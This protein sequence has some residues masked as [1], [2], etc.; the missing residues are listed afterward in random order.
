MVNRPLGGGPL[1]NTQYIYRGADIDFI[2]GTLLN[3]GVIRGQQAK[4]WVAIPEDPDRDYR[5]GTRLSEIEWE[6]FP[7]NDTNFDTLGVT[8]G[9]TDSLL[10]T[11]RFTG[12]HNT[13][14]VFDA[15]MT[16]FEKVEYTHE[17]M[18]EHA[19]ALTQVLKRANGEIHVPGRGL[20][21]TT[22]TSVSADG[23]RRTVILNWGKDNLPATNPNSRFADENEWIANKDSVTVSGAFKGIVS[24]LTDRGASLKLRNM[25][26]TIEPP[27]MPDVGEGEIDLIYNGLMDRLNRFNEPLYMVILKPNIG[28]SDLISPSD[29]KVAYN[30]NGLVDPEDIPPQF[31][32][33]NDG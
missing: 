20:W 22:K 4:V 11:K 31:L 14:A 10:Q 32:G 3:D 26:E 18:D 29:I 16:P 21:A 24:I 12:S 7:A 15:T 8:G 19:G 30:R 9:M 17:W 28:M 2:N 27:T 33:D 23:T 13:V 25:D 5:E 1:S 6:G